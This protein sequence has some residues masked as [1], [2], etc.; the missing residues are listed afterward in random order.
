VYAALLCCSFRLSFGQCTFPAHHSGELLTYSFEP[1]IAGDKTTLHIT[2]EFQG[3]ATGESKLRLPQEVEGEAYKQEP[4]NNVQP[5]TA[6]TVL[7]DTESSSVKR[8]VYPPGSVVRI[9]Y[10][11]VKDWDGPLNARTR[12]HPT[13]ELNNFQIIGKYALAFPQMDLASEVDARFNWQ[14]LPA[15]WSLVTSFGVDRRCQPFQ[16]PLSKVFEALF[17]GGD[18]RVYH[19][20]VNHKPFI[21]AIRGQWNFTDEEWVRQMRGIVSMER[22]F[23]HDNDFPYFFSTLTPYPNYWAG[24]SGTAYTN[25]FM[26]HHLSPEP[27]SAY[28]LLN[29]TAHEIFHTWNWR[30]MGSVG[31]SNLAV[32]W[33]SEGFTEYYADLLLF[34]SHMLS[35]PAYVERTNEKLWDYTFN[36]FKNISHKELVARFRE[37][38]SINN[39]SYHRGF[40]LALWL[41]FQIRHESRNHSS[42]DAMMLELARQAAH[43]KDI[44]F[45]TE[46]LLDTATKY[47]RPD[48]ARQFRQ[49]V[50]QGDTIPFPESLTPCVHLRNVPNPGFELG[51]DLD[52]L[53]RRHQVDHVKPNSEAFKAG[54]RDGQDVSFARGHL[55]DPFATMSLWVH[56]PE[57]DRMISYDPRGGSPQGTV[58]QYRL[59]ENSPSSGVQGYEKR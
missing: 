27:L 39:L 54:L 57:E 44:P 21:V 19:T 47:L 6:G 5:L 48:S 26:M 32:Q 13:L 11:L 36:P 53:S 24:T 59:D 20:S 42:L 28:S 56:S 58:Q 55:N 41:D 51:M 37:N 16:G 49:Y 50:E 12:F 15:A 52:A 1:A 14:A 46:R 40:V 30:K 2:L 9:S 43:K 23:W 31:A 4:F 17:A 29:I 7:S 8:V 25:G 22:K 38:A 34:R 35:L 18:Y 3:N 10:D 33:F 45:T